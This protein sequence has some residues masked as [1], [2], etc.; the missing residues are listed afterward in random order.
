MKHGSAAIVRG[1]SARFLLGVLIRSA[2]VFAVT[3]FFAFPL[4]PDGVG[5]AAAYFGVAVIPASMMQLKQWRE[6]AAA[7]PYADFQVVALI[8]NTLII[9][10]PAV[11][12]HFALFG[13]V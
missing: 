4:L 8:A 2:I 13:R 12:A 10:A 5:K 11:I 3:L 7:D 6:C 1:E 9:L